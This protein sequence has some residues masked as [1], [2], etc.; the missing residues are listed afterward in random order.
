[1]NRDAIFKGVGVVTAFLLLAFL[2]VKGK[3]VNVNQYQNYADLIASQVESD[4][5]VE[6]A[7][8]KERY[9][10]LRN[11]KP[12]EDALVEELKIQE[13]LAQKIP[14][15]VVDEDRLK[16]QKLISRDAQLLEEKTEL[17]NQFQENNAELQNALVQL[18]SLVNQ[19]KNTSDADLER[20]IDD[21]LIYIMATD[22]QLVTTIEKELNAVKAKLNA[23]EFSR[24]EDV[25]QVVQ[26]SQTVLDNKP[27]ADALLDQAVNLPLTINIREL[28]DTYDQSSRVAFR[29]AAIYRNAAYLVALALI[30][31]VAYGL[32]A[33]LRQSTQRTTSVLE[34]ITDAFVA[35]DRTWKVTY[36]NAQAAEVL[37]RSIQGLL[38]Q[39]FWKIFPESLG[40]RYEQQY[41]RAMAEQ[42]VVSF[43]T[44]YAPTQRWLQV[45]GYPGRD[46]LS[47]FL[48]DVTERKQAEEQLMELNR[49]L[50]SRVQDRTTKLMK[51]MEE[52]EEARVKAE[53]ANRS[54]SE[55]LAN[56]SHELR[57][58]LNAIIGYSEMLEEEATDLGEDDF[59]PDLQK[60]QGAGKHLLGLINSVLDLSK[61]E[62]GRMELFLEDFSIREMVEDISGTIVPVAHKNNNHL[63][64]FCPHDVGDLRADQTKL[65]QSLFNLLSNACKFTQGGDITL[66]VE[67]IS[68]VDNAIYDG[69]WFRFI[70]NDTG[71]GMKDD[72][73]EK[74]FDAFTQADASTT[75]KY[76]GTGLGL[77][78]TKQF[79][80][81][82]GG[83]IKVESAHGQG[84]TFSLVIPQM[85]QPSNPK[86]KPFF[87]PAL[88]SEGESRTIPSPLTGQSSNQTILVIDDDED[89]REILRRSLDEAGYNVV[90]AASGEQ[91]LALASELLP[92]AITLDVMM[93]QMDGWSVLRQLKETPVVAEI[94]VI[95]LSIVDD[96]PMGHSLGAADYLTKP[97][98]RSRLLS[99]LETHL[100]G[101]M[102]PTILVV[103]DDVNAREIMG[104]FLQRQDWTVE[105]ASNG[106][107]A[108]Q[109]L[110][111]NLPD[112]IVLDLMMPEMDGFEFIQVLRQN[113]DWQDIPVIVLTAKA[114]T[115]SDQQQLEGVARVYQKADLN[116]QELINELQTMVSAKAGSMPSTTDSVSSTDTVSSAS[117]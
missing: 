77:A 96:R 104:R 91:G 37:K 40:A 12:L 99:V 46:G 86:G 10:L 82:M 11:D 52:A 6:L 67:Q 3:S 25:S 30:G 44:Y 72:Q 73:I 23:G 47:L 36:V 102:S 95:L 60:I 66:T 112:L 43:E 76:G 114:L 39:D 111:E 13:E 117:D 20:L 81:M 69:P 85:V 92:D 74:I 78:I 14:D 35:V 103:E 28:E 70:V 34:N 98:D 5:E 106:R 48:Q 89:A 1:M 110:D 17:V 49:D 61:I 83:D 18:P 71:I 57:T 97:I 94:P 24:S 87:A 15:F 55:F 50:D 116:R 58:P 113:S 75:R 59:V 56:M 108:L 42:T 90:C 29:Q 62:A 53:D 64:I 63:S 31:V 100:S 101:R 21:V 33:R 8:L 79:I 32:V 107:E 68:T 105:L 2:G 88:S 80:N 16:L 93:P 65:R 54:K 9:T 41:R 19:L 45:R 51:A 27:F 38:E 84:T 22:E 109:Y 4:T 26:L 115:A 7:L